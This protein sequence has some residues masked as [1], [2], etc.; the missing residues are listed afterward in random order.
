MLQDAMTK[1]SQSPLHRDAGARQRGREVGEVHTSQA[2]FAVRDAL[3]HE[4]E[5]TELEGLPAAGWCDFKRIPDNPQTKL[6]IKVFARLE[7]A[8]R[9]ERLNGRLRHRAFQINRRG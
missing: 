2:A 4:E 5:K 8:A 7:L 1:P 3:S 6:W 9:V